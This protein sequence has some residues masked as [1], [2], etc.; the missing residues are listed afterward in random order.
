MLQ[1]CDYC[2]AP[3][4]AAEHPDKVHPKYYVND[5]DTTTIWQ[6]PPISR[7]RRFNRIT[8][9]IDLQQ[10]WYIVYIYGMYRYFQIIW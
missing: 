9:E 3:E 7:G 6:S 10:V 8:L 4:E 2:Y 5:G 1:I